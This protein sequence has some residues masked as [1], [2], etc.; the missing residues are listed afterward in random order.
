MIAI[1]HVHEHARATTGNILDLD[2][3]QVRVGHRLDGG[4]VM[5]QFLGRMTQ[6]ILAAK[7][8]PDIFHGLRFDALLG[9]QAHSSALCFVDHLVF[10]E[11]I[12][13]AAFQRARR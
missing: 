13:D 3:R 11:R 5:G 7:T 1:P 8:R 9:Q 10:V 2:H 12:L 6:K 4:Q